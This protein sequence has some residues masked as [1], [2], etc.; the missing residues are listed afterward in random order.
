MI[1][2]LQLMAATGMRFG[3]REEEVSTI[4]RALKGLAKELDIPILALSQLSRSVEQ[5]EGAEG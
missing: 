3:N 1:V 4:S 2:Y 5:R